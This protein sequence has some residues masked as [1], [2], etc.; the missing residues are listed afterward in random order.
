[1]STHFLIIV[2]GLTAFSRGANDVANAVG[3]L[4]KAYTLNFSYL[5]LWGGIG[6]AI[7]LLTLGRRVVRTVGMEITEMRP[8]TA[9]SAQISTM[10]V[11][12]LGTLLGFPLSGTQILVAAIVGVGVVE[13]KKIQHET[14]KEIA[15]SWILTLPI[16][17]L[18]GIIIYPVIKG[19]YLFLGL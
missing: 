6:M 15:Y 14:V 19:A 13:K 3:I 5:L 12:F 7:G 16:S 11:L 2:V 10:L 9:L 1:M 18:I 8:S 17:A 4:S